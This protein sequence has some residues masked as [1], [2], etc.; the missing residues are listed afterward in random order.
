LITIYGVFNI[1]PCHI[2]SP[3][4]GCRAVRSRKTSLIRCGWVLPVCVVSQFAS[5]AK[6]TP[7]VTNV[8]SARTRSH[9]RTMS[10]TRGTVRRITLTWSM[11]SH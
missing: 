2:W 10:V 5:Y 7:G 4:R 6:A 1:L 8:V 9:A 3:S 11:S